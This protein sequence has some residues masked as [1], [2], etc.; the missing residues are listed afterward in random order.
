M[1]LRLHGALDLAGCFQVRETKDGRVF[2][3]GLIRVKLQ[4]ME[5]CEKVQRRAAPRHALARTLA[6]THACACV[7]ALTHALTH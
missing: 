6:R 3:E 7:H 4:T 5:D 1:T 2:C